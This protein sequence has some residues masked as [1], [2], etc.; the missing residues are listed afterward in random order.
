MKIGGKAHRTIWLADDGWSVEAID[1]SR[2]PH[3]LVVIRLRTVDDAWRAIREMQVRGAPLIGAAA[4]YGLC[5]ALREDPSD[6]NLEDA[7]GRLLD[8][9][10][11]AV[12]LRWALDEMRRAVAPLTPAARAAAAYAR[13]AA[14]CDDDV[15]TCRAIGM[16]GLPLIA[17]AWERA[18]RSRPVQVLTHCNAGWLATV[19][20]GTALAPVYAAHDA[21]V[22]VHVFV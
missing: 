11:T 1:Q 4:A 5:L 6:R 8:T 15:A 12:N 7:V 14:L 19:D 22:P 17:S 16:H 18:G 9:R 2:L 20:W 10:P 21:G 13:A 3:E